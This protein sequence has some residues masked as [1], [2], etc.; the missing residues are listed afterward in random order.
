MTCTG[1]FSAS[2]NDGSQDGGER[3]VF[4]DHGVAHKQ[5]SFPRAG[6]QV[7]H[8][9]QALVPFLFYELGLAY[10]R[11]HGGHR[12][13]LNLRSNGDSVIQKHHEVHVLMCYHGKGR[14]VEEPKL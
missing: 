13:H 11:C 3:Q 4:L 14:T 2:L 5:K 6:G 1:I 12:N 8:P 10:R 7:N 9:R